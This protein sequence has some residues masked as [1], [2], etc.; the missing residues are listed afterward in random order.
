MEA[1]TKDS[2]KNEDL[3]EDV[4]ELSY[5]RIFNAEEYSKLI[6]G[7]KPQAMEDKWFVYFDE[8]YLYLHRSWTGYCIY[9]LRLVVV[10]QGYK[11]DEVLANRNAE[12]YNEKDDSYD[13]EIMDFLVS[14]LLLG[15]SKPFPK[16]KGYDKNDKG[17]L[18]HHISGTG[19]KEKVVSGGKPWWKFW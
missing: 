16:P 10:D 3:P 12:Q 17:V 15:E 4:A 2:W 6:L 7:L 5:N 9:R 18:Q 11:V 8:G 13:G 14:N 1:T 19:Y